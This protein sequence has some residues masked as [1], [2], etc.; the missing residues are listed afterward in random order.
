MIKNYKQKRSTL[1]RD[2]TPSLALK[3]SFEETSKSAEEELL[4]NLRD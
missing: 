1:P 4:S 3:R 2:A